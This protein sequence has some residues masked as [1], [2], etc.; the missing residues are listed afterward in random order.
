MKE[1]WRKKYKLL[2]KIFAK[3]YQKNSKNI[4]FIAEIQ[5]L[6]TNQIIHIAKVYLNNVCKDIITL[7]IMFTPG[8][9]FQN[10]P[11]KTFQRQIKI[12]NNDF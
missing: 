7:M 1:L 3:I 4:K 12:N 10:K 5:L 9:Q 2:L 6:R 11:R 8:I